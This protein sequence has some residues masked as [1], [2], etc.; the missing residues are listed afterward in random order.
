[1][2][3]A[4]PGLVRGSMMMGVSLIA[5]G[6]LSMLT[7]IILAR[8]VSVG[9]FG[10]YSITLSLQS[11]VV[12]FS[13]FSIGVA[14]AKFV[15][16]YSVRDVRHALH[17]ARTGLRLVLLFSTLTAIAYF[18]LADPIGKGLYQE[19]G[20]V[21]LI[22][23]SA[24]V[25][26]SS[27]V[28]S[29]TYGIA[30]GNHRMKLMS[31][32]QVSIPVIGLSVIM[33]LLPFVGIKVAFIGL[34]I[35][36]TTVA[37]SAMYWLGRT[38]FPLVGRVEADASLHYRSKLLS[39]AVPAVMCTVMVSPLYWFG[40]TVLALDSGFLAVGHFAIAMVF[41]Q[42]L[43][44]LPNSVVIPLVP[45]VSEMTVHSREQIESLVSRSLRTVSVLLFPLFFAIAL[46]SRDIVGVFYGPDYYESSDPVYL[47]VT[48][49]YYFAMATI[50]GAAIIGMGR[51]WVGLGLNFI[52]AAIFIVLVLVVT[53]SYGPT[54]LGIAF[55]VSYG[56]HLAV[57]I[58][59]SN[60][61]LRLKI[62]NVLVIILPSVA[63][64]A[65]GF[66]SL[67]DVGDV[68][69]LARAALLVLGT[70]LIVYLGREEFGLVLGRLLKR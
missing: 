50:V 61:V 6:A 37:L 63:L 40:N 34:F 44:V 12:L 5:A 69:L 28:L 30:Q 22:P 8:S 19:T 41:F 33:L 29:L 24:M 14:V 70:G 9:E 7:S 31:S 20:V 55:V 67:M 51:M 10:F 11:V 38:G 52:W 39:F 21:D 35:A 1:M 47:M 45:R 16:E 68:P 65:A 32:M 54:G 27:A 3:S 15:A 48:A 46:F 56:V 42:A 53:P 4:R 18:A 43:S 66:Y 2:N 59:V 25:V 36:Q 64:F 17:F 60:M 62:R 49:C 23:F 57:S 26:F 13:S 58:A